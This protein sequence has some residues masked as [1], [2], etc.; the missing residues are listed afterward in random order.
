MDL[1]TVRADWDSEQ[2]AW[3][4]P[5][6]LTQT[7]LAELMSQPKGT[8]EAGAVTPLKRLR[9]RHHALARL[10]ASGG[11][12]MQDAAIITGYEA[13]T[14]STL[15]QD[16]LF[17]DLVLFYQNEVNAEYRTMQAQ[18][19]GLGEDAVAELRKRVEDDP[20]ALGATF[21]LD[22]VVK[23]ADRTG[24]GPTS[25]T[26]TEVSVTVD[27]ASKMKAARIRAREAS[28]QI[29]VEA[30]DITPMRAAE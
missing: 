13:A 5:R 3:G 30:R 10:L 18:L 2:L 19:A 6:A 7:D 15:K 14:I 27:L 22:L 11:C 4:E 1:R 16:P 8:S 20:A 17:Q 25:T 12:S 9:E 26:K 28:A 23:I 24:N 29:D 21:L